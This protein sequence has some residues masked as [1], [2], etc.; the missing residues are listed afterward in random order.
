[1]TTGCHPGTDKRTTASL[2]AMNPTPA[3]VEAL[4]EKVEDR[5]RL[6]A[7]PVVSVAMATYNHGPFI[8]QALDSVLMQQTDFPYEVVIKEDKSTDGTR[9]TVCE[10][11][12][13]HPDKIRLLLCR[14]NL[15]SQGLKIGI[16]SRCRGRYIAKL[17]GDDYWTDPLKLQK[18][19]DALAGDPALSFCFHNAEIVQESYFSAGAPQVCFE[20]GAGRPCRGPKPAP[21]LALPDL[22]AENFIP[23][24]SVLA[25]T[26]A[27]LPAPDWLRRLPFGDWGL[28]IHLLRQGDAAYIDE[29][30]GAYRV[31]E[32]G[33]WSSANTAR[34]HALLI[35]HF[36]V[37]RQ[38]LD[39]CYR[40][41]L[42]RLFNEQVGHFARVAAGTLRAGFQDQDGQWLWEE[43]RRLAALSPE[44]GVGAGRLVF[45]A[46]EQLFL[47]AANSGARRT[48]WRHLLRCGQANPRY[49]LDR[50]VLRRAV[51]LLWPGRRRH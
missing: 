31:H 1:M 6:P 34:K 29:T 37:I 44:S 4:I 39:V 11:Q 9:E 41:G 45:L 15:Y 8:R 25:R 17:E 20:D 36:D 21:R 30:M 35:R 49:L 22:L 40:P 33:V 5:S 13:R 10:Y 16:H 48:A 43:A 38:I 46:C 28:W 51:G 50:H 14:K 12:R 42:D 23:T 18:Q 32:G 24:A 26:D 27:V 7:A 47:E 2:Y 3:D 19:V